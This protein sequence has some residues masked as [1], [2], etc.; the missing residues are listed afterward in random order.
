VFPA[1]CS[2]IGSL[3]LKIGGGSRL[4]QSTAYVDFTGRGPLAQMEDGKERISFIDGNL[5]C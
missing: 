2:L 1:S 4:A 5:T 3:S